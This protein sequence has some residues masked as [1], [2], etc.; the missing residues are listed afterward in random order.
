LRG[1]AHHLDRVIRRQPGASRGDGAQRGHHRGFDRQRVHVNLGHAAQRRGT[2]LAPA[3]IECAPDPEAANHCDVVI[4]EMAEVV[5]AEDLAPAD[6]AAVACRVAAEIAEIAGA[7]KTEMA[8][9]GF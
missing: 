6:A 5:R 1:I 9:R 2:F 3:K 8:G 4:G 7:G